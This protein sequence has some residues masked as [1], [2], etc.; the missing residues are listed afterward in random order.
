M[1]I[2]R[3]ISLPFE[4]NLQRHGCPAFLFKV[5]RDA[6]G[7]PFRRPFLADSVESLLFRIDDDDQRLPKVFEGSWMRR[8]YER[9]A[10]VPKM[11]TLWKKGSA[12]TH[13][14]AR[15]LETGYDAIRDRKTSQNFEGISRSRIAAWWV[16]RAGRNEHGG[17]DICSA[18]TIERSAQLSPRKGRAD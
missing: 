7:F 3:G 12:S 8:V 18:E 6:Q 11:T 15:S 16:P 17:V 2:T 10:E 9:K 14:K 13:F 5:Q 4:T 1:R